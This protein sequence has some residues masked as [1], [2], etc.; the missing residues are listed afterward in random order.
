MLLVEVVGRKLGKV[1]QFSQ[2]P[3]DD[4]VAFIQEKRADGVSMPAIWLRACCCNYLVAVAR[5]PTSGQIPQTRG[6]SDSKSGGTPLDRTLRSHPSVD[7]ATGLAQNSAAAST[8][9]AH[10]LYTPRVAHSD[11][12]SRLG[13]FVNSDM[14]TKY[15][16]AAWRLLLIS[17]M[18]I[19]LS[20]LSIL[21]CKQVAGIPVMRSAPGVR[22]DTAVHARA[23]AIAV[24]VAVLV[25]LALPIVVIYVMYD[26]MGA[27][28]A[29]RVG[30]FQG[31]S[32][33]LA[34]MVMLTKVCMAS[35]PCLGPCMCASM[36]RKRWYRRWQ[37]GQDLPGDVLVPTAG[38]PFRLM[39]MRWKAKF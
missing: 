10:E 2:S 11:D 29:L 6:R 24:I 3:S 15:F 38:D 27:E 21:D 36:R 22:C 30:R 17:F 23:T 16:W 39:A 5:D 26:Q 13:T 25:G 20:A 14:L 31:A 1:V 18:A 4:T 8:D 28:T 32:F 7:A 34:R 12:W 19:L 33:Y 35:I 37:R 9:D